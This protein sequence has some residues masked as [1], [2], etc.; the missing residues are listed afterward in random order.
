MSKREGILDNERVVEN[1]VS[2]PSSCTANDT[3]EI[4]K[5]KHAAPSMELMLPHD[6]FGS[7]SLLD[8]HNE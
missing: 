5:A 8:I 6:H 1:V 7:A 2:F 3:T 4:F